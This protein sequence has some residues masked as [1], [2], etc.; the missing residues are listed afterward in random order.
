[1]DLDARRQALADRHQRALDEYGAAW[2]ELAELSR[3]DPLTGRV[4]RTSE[5]RAARFRFRR[6]VRAV[7]RTQPRRYTR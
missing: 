2:H 3:P 6:A 5:W 4:W 7:R 1:M